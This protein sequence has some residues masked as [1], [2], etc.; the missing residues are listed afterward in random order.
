MNHTEPVHVAAASLQ[1][2]DAAEC[3]RLALELLTCWALRVLR[4]F[5]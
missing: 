1:D 4:L 2:A 5:G 3:W